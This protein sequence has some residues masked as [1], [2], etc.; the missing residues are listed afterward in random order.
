MDEMVRSKV[1]C[2]NSNGARDGVS[3]STVEGSEK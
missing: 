1:I 3:E 2:P